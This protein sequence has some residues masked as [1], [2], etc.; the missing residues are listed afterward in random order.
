MYRYKQ[1]IASAFSLRTFEGQTTEAYA[2]IAV[3][4]R[5]NTLGLPIRAAIG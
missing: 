4:N 5:M 3:L 1:L 2:G